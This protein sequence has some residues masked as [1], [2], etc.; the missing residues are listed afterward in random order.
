MELKR[1]LF[2]GIAAALLW[3]LPGCGDGSVS[4]ATVWGGVA[5]I[6]A[7]RAELS[8]VR[9]E[10]IP[11]WDEW[12]SL[13]Q[14][15]RIIIHGVW[16]MAGAAEPVKFQCRLNR[17]SGSLYKVNFSAENAG[18][19]FTVA[20]DL[21][22]VQRSAALDF[23]GRV[24][25][26]SFRQ[27]FGELPELKQGFADVSGSMLQ[28]GSKTSFPLLTMIPAKNSILQ[29]GSLP[30]KGGRV[31]RR[32]TFSGKL[33]FSFSGGAVLFGGIK[34][35]PQE[36][37]VDQTQAV[38]KTAVEP[39][40]P[41]QTSVPLKGDGRCSLTGDGEW[42]VVAELPE[43]GVFRRG[44][45]I[46]PL[47]SCRISGKGN[48]AGGKWIFAG[49]GASGSWL[50][51]SGTVTAAN[52][53]VKGEKQFRFQH[54]NAAFI[55]DTLT[56]E[57]GSLEIPCL[58]GR[59]T[60]L[61]H[62][63]EFRQ[64][65][66][67]GLLYSGSAGEAALIRKGG[68][69]LRLTD[70]EWK[71]P[72]WIAGDRIFSPES[73]TV[74][75]KQ[76]LLTGRS[77]QIAIEKVH[78]TVTLKEHSWETELA[79]DKMKITSG[80]MQG[81]GGNTDWKISGS[82]DPA[83]WIEVIGAGKSGNVQ[84]GL[85]S[86][87]CGQWDMHLGLRS[88]LAESNLFSWTGKNWRGQY[89][90]S[91]KWNAE[92]FSI[93]A[94]RTTKNLR[95]GNISLTGADFVLPGVEVRGVSFLLPFGGAEAGK[96]RIHADRIRYK[97]MTVSGVSVD[98]QNTA[99]GVSLRGRGRSDLTGGACF[100][101]GVLRKDLRNGVVEY[102]MPSA[103]LE[104]ELKIAELLPLPGGWI[105]SGKLG[106]S[107]KILW[108]NSVPRWQGKYNFSG[109]AR[110]ADCMVEELSGQIEPANGGIAD[111]QL[112]FRRLT[113]VSGECSDGELQFRTEQQQMIVQNARW[114]AWGG[115]WKYLRDGEFQVKGVQLAGLLPVNGWQD[116]IQGKFS[117]TV[118]LNGAFHVQKGDLKSDGS[119]SLALAEME[120]YRLLPKKEFDMNALAFTSAAFRDF[121]YNTLALRL[122]RRKN[123]VLLRISGE[124]RPAKA[125]PF[126][127]EK[128]GFFRPSVSG[129]PGFEGNV[130][131]GCGYRIP[132]RDLVPDRSI[133]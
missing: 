85:L 80:K 21:D 113:S 126:V 37:T 115:H 24:S 57:C 14:K 49:E 64:L 110:N 63:G 54:G 108:E 39:D 25:P 97:A 82:R 59:V 16:K 23:N 7:D 132:L 31:D 72:L 29:F 107:G 77:G 28:S 47:R 73:G 79:A 5:E 105:F 50:K 90:S 44:D 43:A 51:R 104:K 89:G 30:V 27:Y 114:E 52:V 38:F 17:Q 12:A 93:Q 92:K 65:S 120:K 8:N 67:G 35:Y 91:G 69:G 103:T 62:K 60:M 56:L 41:W 42:S 123:G 98:L 10:M 71:M 119:G 33:E 68:G 121:R 106:G 74:R 45:L 76:L 83:G 40:L 128:S 116:A 117:G 125:V 124:G 84:T 99:D 127:L 1:I 133:K 9:W 4:S 34:L 2:A 102:A 3:F 18:K 78:S 11:L 55:P 36:L 46:L 13:P 101:T 96:S 58:N 81:V 95:Q 32:E 109:F 19:S 75:A 26:E 88:D 22:W 111:A 66:S 15:P 131:I 70:P 86:G 130:E 118:S 61:R 129:E 94:D 53:Q 112:L 48:A 100:I 20:G 6:S 122:I 87:D